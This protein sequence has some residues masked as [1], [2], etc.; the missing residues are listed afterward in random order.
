VDKPGTPQTALRVTAI[1]AARTTPDYPALQVMNAAL[2]GM[3]SSR[4]NNNLREDKG[5]SYG[6]FSQFRYDRTPGP[7]VIAGSVRL[8]VTGAA[9]RE[10]LKEVRGMREQPLPAAEL[11]AA[12]ASQVLSL[13]GQFETNSAIGA[14]L[15]ETFVFGL[16]LDYYNR[17][18]AQFA[19]V[20]ADQ[21]RGAARK[22]LV[23]ERM[24][25]VAVGDRAKIVP[26]LRKLKLGPAEVRDTD[27]QL[28]RGD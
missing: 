4:I 11:A 14:S 28:L 27:G 3:F 19:G 12:R 13:P 23:P 24:I 26:Q 21:V 7:F 10:I 9:V 16:P 2:G 18:P 17:L 20:T 25:V 6:V 8:D 5:Y 15:A 1:G 22:Y